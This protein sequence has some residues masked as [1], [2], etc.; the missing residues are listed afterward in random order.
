MSDE[1][2]KS[3]SN[4][5]EDENNRIVQIKSL[6]KYFPQTNRTVVNNV[7]FDLYEN[8]ITALLGHNGAGKF[9]SIIHIILFKY[10]K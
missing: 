8:E 2:F 7:S 6:I 9:I 5:D 1:S 4:E 3:L 10:L